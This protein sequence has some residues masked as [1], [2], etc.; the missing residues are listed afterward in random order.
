MSAPAYSVLLKA[1]Q[2]ETDEESGVWI[3]LLRGGWGQ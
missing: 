3:V 1:P 2:K